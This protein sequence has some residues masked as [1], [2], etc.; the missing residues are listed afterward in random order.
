M[1][2]L[3]LV[4]VGTHIH[5][6]CSS[7]EQRL[8]LKRMGFTPLGYRLFRL[9]DK[10]GSGTISEE[11]FTSVFDALITS[12]EE[13][14]RMTFDAVRAPSTSPL[15]RRETIVEYVVECWMCAHQF[16]ITAKQGSNEA[17]LSRQLR[18]YA[19]NNLPRL[20]RR[21]I[22]SLIPFEADGLVD[23]NAFVKWGSVDRSITAACGAMSVEVGVTLR[24]V[25]CPDPSPLSSPSAS[26]LK[27]KKT[28]P[29]S[30]SPHP[31]AHSSDPA[32]ISAAGD[33]GTMNVIRQPHTSPSAYPSIN[34]ERHNSHNRRPANLPPG[35]STIMAPMSIPQGD[36][37][38]GG[39]MK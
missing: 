32:A 18:A 31:T 9:F 28:P 5:S 25:L 37:G 26:R 27:Q 35:V 36:K 17:L 34:L 8:R 23:A 13:K 10:D 6:L 33:T 30:R 14:L 4:A 29:T 3:L 39:G 12:N 22:E 1:L 7:Q 19:K 24:D 16:L 21:V 15:V 2:H 20:R 11:E 38:G